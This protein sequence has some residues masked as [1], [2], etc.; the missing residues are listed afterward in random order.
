MYGTQQKQPESFHYLTGHGS[1][2]YR[3]SE[4][5]LVFN[6]IHMYTI[7]YKIIG[8]TIYVTMRTFFLYC[9][10]RLLF[11]QYVFVRP[12]YT[13]WLLTRTEAGNFFFSQWL[14]IICNVTCCALT[15]RQY[16]FPVYKIL[17]II[18]YSYVVYV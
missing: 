11:L 5:V 4:V 9:L 10:S 1:R 7:W 8:Y 6:Y 13:F 16:C 17:L 14:K 18:E 3:C 15:V 2:L 12:G